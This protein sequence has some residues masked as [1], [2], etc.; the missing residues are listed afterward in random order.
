VGVGIDLKVAPFISVRPIQ[1]DYLVTRFN[2]GTQNQP[3]ISAGV[4][5]HF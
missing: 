5:L 3:R 2:S 1:F 4:V